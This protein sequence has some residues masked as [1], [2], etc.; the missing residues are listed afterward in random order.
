MFLMRVRAPFATFRPFVAGSYRQTLPFVTPTAAYGLLLNLAGIESR[1]VMPDAMATDTAYGL[2][3]CELAIG[4]LGP[5]AVGRM[6]QQLHNYPVG[7]TG[8]AHAPATRGSKYNIQPILREI[9]VGVDA[10]VAIRGNDELEGLV[11]HGLERGLASKRIDGAPRYGVPF[12]G[13]NAFLVDSIDEIGGEKQGVLPARWYCPIGRLPDSDGPRAGTCR[14]PI[15]IDRNDMN[16]TK[17]ELMAPSEFLSTT[18]E[19]AWITIE[20]PARALEETSSGS[21]PRRARATR[22]A[23]EPAAAPKTRHPSERTER[24]DEQAR[25]PRK[26]KRP[27]KYAAPGPSFTESDIEYQTDAVYLA[28]LGLGPVPSGDV[29]REAAMRLREGGLV[30]FERFR[31][32]GPLGRS[33]EAAVRK[34][35]RNGWIDAPRRG[36]LRAVATD[37]GQ[38]SKEMW[39]LC[40]TSTDTSECLNDEERIMQCAEW[41][42][43]NMGLHYERLRTGG[44]IWKGIAAALRRARRRGD[45]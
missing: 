14:M 2:P 10:F 13:D 37:A 6:L 34:A 1:R 38:Y 41:A 20:P 35:R 23:P 5:P 40:I 21:R 15:W 12:L 9:L 43:E 16:R 25:T 24:A 33:I 28:L 39:D 42:A 19:E 17:T 4:M 30:S 18:P 45:I 44:K 27:E 26:R 31:A 8:A 32:G 7:N 36:L 22:A 29:A 11:R 3:S